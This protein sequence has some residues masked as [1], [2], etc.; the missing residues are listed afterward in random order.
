M[1]VGNWYSIRV[2]GQIIDAMY[3]GTTNDGRYIMR[4]SQNN[5][6]HV[7]IY[8]ESELKNIVVSN[9]RTYNG[10]VKHVPKDIE[11]NKLFLGW[12]WYIFLMIVVSIFKGGVVGW[13]LI[14]FFFFSWRKKVKAEATYYT[15][16]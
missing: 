3:T 8:S 16:E 9:K 1:N 6:L 10:M 11:I 5:K 15:K 14:S 13:G 12:V 4:Y 2:N 7:G